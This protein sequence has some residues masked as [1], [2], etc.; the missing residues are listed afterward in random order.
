MREERRGEGKAE[1]GVERVEGRRGG[2]GGGGNKKNLHKKIAHS[3]I[4]AR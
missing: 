1:K 3:S 4:L 2:D